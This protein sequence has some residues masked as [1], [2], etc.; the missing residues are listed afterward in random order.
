V[1]QNMP[2]PSNADRKTIVVR[3]PRKYRSLVRGFVLWLKTHPNQ[4]ALW[5]CEESLSQLLEE[6]ETKKASAWKADVATA[7][8]SAMQYLQQQNRR[9]G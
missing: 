2:Q 1:K 7:Y 6:E 8:S 5:N 3:I 9:A 4:A